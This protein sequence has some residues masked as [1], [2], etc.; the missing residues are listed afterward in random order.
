MPVP[1]LISFSIADTFTTIL[2]AMWFHIPPQCTQTP[3]NFHTWNDR[4]THLACCSR[5]AGYWY[6]EQN[7]T[8]ERLW[9]AIV[10]GHKLNTLMNLDSD[11]LMSVS[12]STS[13]F[14]FTNPIKSSHDHIVKFARELYKCCSSKLCN[15]I[16]MLWP[17]EAGLSLWIEKGIEVPR[18]M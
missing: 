9:G 2:G 7:W 3:L 6:G 14:F 8:H 5:A 4:F 11:K 13:V 15:S 18:S 17:T 16:K 12:E 10:L 1:A